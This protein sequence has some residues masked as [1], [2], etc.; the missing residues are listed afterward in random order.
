MNKTSAGIG[1]LNLYLSL[2]KLSFYTENCRH[3]FTLFP[4]VALLPHAAKPTLTTS[5]HAVVFTV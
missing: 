1:Y 2:A 5:E 3:A 4:P